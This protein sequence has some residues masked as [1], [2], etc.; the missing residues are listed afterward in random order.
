MSIRTIIAF[1]AGVG[2]KT[3]ATAI[4]VGVPVAQNTSA[5]RHVHP[6]SV[7]TNCL[8]MQKANETRIL[9]DSRLY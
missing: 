8:Q 7:G 3:N 4:F 2:T 6:F 9:R 5:M 1:A